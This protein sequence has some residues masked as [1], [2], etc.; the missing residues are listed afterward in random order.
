MP[1]SRTQH[2]LTRVG[3]ES[4]TSRSGVRGINHQAIALPKLF[5]DCILT[6]IMCI[7]NIDYGYSL[8][9]PQ[10]TRI[11]CF[12]QKYENSQNDQTE[13]SHFLQK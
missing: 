8:E 11:L 10:C 6:P 12:E 1:C 9:P 5:C 4:P 7:Q 13:N 3:L 2:G